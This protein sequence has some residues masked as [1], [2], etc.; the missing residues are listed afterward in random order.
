VKKL[1]D[2][3]VSGVDPSVVGSGVGGGDSGIGGVSIFT[4][5]K[6]RRICPAYA[7]LSC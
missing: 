2:S 7:I 5:N 1:M 6:E 4:N 3:M